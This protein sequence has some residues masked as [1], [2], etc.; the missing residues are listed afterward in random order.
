MATNA[1]EMIARV[2]MDF[3]WR[4]GDNSVNDEAATRS[5]LKEAR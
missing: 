1:R 5:P 4:L 2:E 3:A